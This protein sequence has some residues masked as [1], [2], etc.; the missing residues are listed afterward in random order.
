ML[1]VT[2][3][4][5]VIPSRSP[6][7]IAYFIMSICAFIEGKSG[8]TPKDNM[9]ETGDNTIYSPSGSSNIVRADIVAYKSAFQ[10]LVRSYLNKCSRNSE[11]SGP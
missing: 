5:G 11:E 7:D 10:A 9:E 2:I 4:I 1:L 6:K 3:P 8:H